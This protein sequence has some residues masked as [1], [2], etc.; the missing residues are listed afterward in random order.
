MRSPLKDILL[1]TEVVTFVEVDNYIDAESEN[2]V[3]NKTIY[4]ALHNRY[5]KNETSS[6]VEI[7]NA[8]ENLDL[9][10]NYVQK[11]EGQAGEVIYRTGD[12]NGIVNQRIF[13]NSFLVCENLQDLDLCK[14]GIPIDISM[15]DI[16]NS[17][18]E[19]GNLGDL[20]YPVDTNYPISGVGVGH[21]YINDDKTQ[22]IQTYNTIDFCGFV[23]ENK[24]SKYD[25][26]LKFSSSAPDDDMIGF[27]AAAAKDIDGIIHTIS[28]VRTPNNSN[29]SDDFHKNY[30]WY[31]ILDGTDGV[32]PMN[33]VGLQKCL[34][35]GTLGTNSEGSGGWNNFA[36]TLVNVVR[37]GNTIKAT[38]TPFDQSKEELSELDLQDEISIDIDQLIEDYSDDPNVVGVLNLFKDQKCSIGFCAFSQIG[39]TF[40]I[41]KFRVPTES[42]LPIV[43]LVDGTVEEFNVET[44]EYDVVGHDID[45]VFK[46]GTL[47]FNS[48]TNKLFYSYGQSA[49]NITKNINSY[50]TYDLRSFKG[51]V[52]AVYNLL[53][54][55]G[56]NRE[57][58]LT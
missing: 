57:Q 35:H 47:S 52:K 6:A 10:K 8:L 46:D 41:L 26:L 28:F 34:T 37:N 30:H 55:L 23:T 13:N 22:I 48:I 12:N 39:S 54:S 9:S 43:N 5:T 36:G 44:K 27:V 19:F 51:L 18:E 42:K 21:W 38:T 17:K 33:T 2:P 49:I 7:A 11:R 53:V 31:C 3:A 20:H 25:I 32:N 45:D 40:N 50:V 24:F 4:T 15:E 29:G 56:V 14:N 16:F 58:L 1:P